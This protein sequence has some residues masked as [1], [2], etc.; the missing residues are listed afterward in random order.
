MKSALLQ[1]DVRKGEESLQSS[2]NMIEEV[3][4]IGQKDSFVHRFTNSLSSLIDIQKE[5]TDG[6]DRS[7][8]PISQCDARLVVNAAAANTP[9][10]QAR[11]MTTIE[12]ELQQ[13]QHSLHKA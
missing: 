7:P 9:L 4:T 1:V 2:L 10:T 6:S 5:W 3:M 12:E 8:A 13:L 11:S